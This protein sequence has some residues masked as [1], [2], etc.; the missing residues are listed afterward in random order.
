MNKVNDEYR[1]YRIDKEGNEVRLDDVLAVKNGVYITA[2]SQNRVGLKTYA[3][4]TLLANEYDSIDVME[5]FL[6]DGK[7]QKSVVAAVK[8][9]RGY[10]FELE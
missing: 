2:D 9:N 3:G 1:Y 5:T 6:T 7:F 8:N 4:Q 10:I